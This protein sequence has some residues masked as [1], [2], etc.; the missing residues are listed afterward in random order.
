MKTVILVWIN[1]ANNFK[2]DDVNN[3]WGLGDLIRGTIAMYQLSKKMNFNLIV[4]MH[5]HSVSKFLINPHN[6]YSAYLENAKVDFILNPEEHINNNPDDIMYFCTNINCDMCI[7]DDIKDYMRDLLKPNQDFQKYIDEKKAEIPFDSFNIIHY[8]L[9]DE[10]LVR[11]NSNNNNQYI[12]NLIQNKEN[13]DV[14]LSDS[15]YFKECAKNSTDIFMFNI[16]PQHMGYCKNSDSIRDS[17]FEFFLISL[18]RKIKTFTVYNHTSG[19]VRWT[20]IIHNLELIII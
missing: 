20:S 9:G 2:Q 4:D 5:K 18:A 3:F 16:E 13:N 17:L 8:R 15:K 6:P 11:N 12:N 19:F 7:G 14:L 1:E 10:E